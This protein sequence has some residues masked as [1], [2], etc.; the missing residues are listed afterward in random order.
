MDRSFC[1]KEKKVTKCIPG[2]EKYVKTK[3]GRTML[4]CTYLSC[5]IT[6]TCFVKNQGN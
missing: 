5:G 2:S 4:K 1:V 3:N 6:K